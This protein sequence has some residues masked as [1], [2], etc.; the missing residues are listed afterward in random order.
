[1]EKNE[2]LTVHK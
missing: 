1:L 2:A